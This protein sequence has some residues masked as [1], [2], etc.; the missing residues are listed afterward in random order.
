MIS[1]SYDLTEFFEK[2]SAHDTHDLIYTAEQEA[3]AAERS[4]YRPVSDLATPDE[5]CREYVAALKSFIG[6]LRY[7]TRMPV[8]ER[9]LPLFQ[10]AEKAL[11]L[12]PRLT[13]PPAKQ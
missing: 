7:Y 13:A 11:A 3:T 9:W 6:F 8:D 10:N 1:E 4:L 12:A 5:V 2:V